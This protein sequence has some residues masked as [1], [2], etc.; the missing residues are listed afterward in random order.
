MKK[1]IPSNYLFILVA[2]SAVGKSILVNQICEEGLWQKAPKYST[3]NN[4]D[5]GEKKEDDVLKIDDEKI[6]ER[7]D[8]SDEQ[9]K[10]N[11]EIRLARMRKLTELCGDGNGTV[12]YKN[13]NIYGISICE[14]IDRLEQTHLAVIISDFH[15]IDKLRADERLKN[16]IKVMYLASTIDEKLLFERFKEREK[17]Q[18]QEE[19]QKMTKT[20]NVIQDKIMILPSA[21]RLQYASKIDDIVRSVSDEW[22]TNFSSYET[23]KTRSLN[24]RMLYNRYIDN[25]KTIDYAVLNFYD[26]EYMYKQVRNILKNIQPKREINTAN[27]P[28]FMVC[29]AKSS[30]KATLME[31]VGDMGTVHNNI[32][33]T[34]KY[35]KRA[36]RPTDGRDGMKAIGKEGKFEDYI[37]KKDIWKWSFHN[38]NREFA[39]S[40]KEINDNIEK[41]IAQIFISNMNVIED[42]K[43]FYPDNIVVLYLHA[44]HESATLNH[45]HKKNTHDLMV[46]I[47]KEH[48]DYTDEQ[49]KEEFDNNPKIQAQFRESVERD[50]KDII[51]VH[52][53]FCEHNIN[54]DHVLLNTGSREDLIEQMT[55]LINYYTKK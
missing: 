3:R 17:K 42:A 8:I 54:T 23:V 49:V 50:K 34:T 11:A 14:I 28:I 41:G 5:V 53:A 16:R 35:A 38:D 7:K 43:K 40:R 52:N 19:L 20:I 26:L 44:T 24:I 27:P 39:V 22:N 47:K 12:Y 25:I 30:G 29:A 51:E 32:V 15:V 36:S 6:D 46:E 1:D 13:D 55:N 33:I 37:D 2:A 31:I 9:R 21:I 10:K 4:R 48:G 45:I 18:Y